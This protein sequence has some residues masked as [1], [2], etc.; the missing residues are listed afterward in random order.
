MVRMGKAVPTR[1]DK[2]KIDGVPARLADVSVEHFDGG[3]VRLVGPTAIESGESAD[4][5]IDRYVENYWATRQRTRR[6]SLSQPHRQ[7][8]AGRGCDRTIVAASIQKSAS[9]TDF[10]ARQRRASGWSMRSTAP[11]QALVQQK[12]LR[13]SRICDL[14][15][16]GRR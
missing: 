3:S 6:R 14:R 11:L 5:L 8:Q 15:C 2:F 12:S 1:I 13:K 7:R 4:A 9:N 10:R 16:T